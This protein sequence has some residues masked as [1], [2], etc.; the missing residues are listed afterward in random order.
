MGRLNK[1]SLEAVLDTALNLGWSPLTLLAMEGLRQG[2]DLKKVE[3]TLE[4]ALELDY[5]KETATRIRLLLEAAR[6]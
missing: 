5:D 3:D 6:K 1:H 2:L 4:Q